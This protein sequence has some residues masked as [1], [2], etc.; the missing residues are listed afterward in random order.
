MRCERSITAVNEFKDTIFASPYSYLQI[1]A[2]C[3]NNLIMR[4]IKVITKLSLDLGILFLVLF[5]N[6]K[7]VC[8]LLRKYCECIINVIYLIYEEQCFI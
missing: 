6:A 1:Q 8:Y 4:F 2:K 7:I 5:M 3:E